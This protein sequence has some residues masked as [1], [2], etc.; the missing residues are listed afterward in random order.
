MAGAKVPFNGSSAID[1][2]NTEAQV[3]DKKEKG[4]NELE[5]NKKKAVEGTQ[6]VENY[7]HDTSKERLDPRVNANQAK[8]EGQYG[9]INGRDFSRTLRL[10]RDADRYNNKPVQHMFS[11]GTRHTGGVKDMGVGYERPRI[12]TME[13]RAMDQSF[14]LDTNQKQLAQQLQAAVNRKDLDAFIACYQQMY[15]IEL[16]RYQAEN[17]MIHYARQLE[18]QQIIAKDTTWFTRQF[19]AE[20]AK[21]IYDLNK[22]NPSFSEMLG[23]YVMSG[24]VPPKLAETIAEEAQLDAYEAALA[25]MGVDINSASD[26]QKQQAWNESELVQQK[27]YN[28]MMNVQAAS[29]ARSQRLIEKLKARKAAK[30][31]GK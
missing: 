12:Q 1:N 2:K 23:S 18:M 14:Q 16:N 15:G 11:V 28:E 17:M 4:V 13:T 24:T 22:E 27:T 9:M 29:N 3:Q 25:K 19:S 5:G 30:Q 31:V 21:A 26:A 10:A 6:A 8:G 7:V 20:T